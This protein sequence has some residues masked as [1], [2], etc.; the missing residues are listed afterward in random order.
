MHHYKNPVKMKESF[1][2][3][4]GLPKVSRAQFIR[5]IDALKNIS[6]VITKI[7]NSLYKTTINLI[8]T[9]YQHL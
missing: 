7:I 8:E 4:H 2:E 5:T 1:R 6:S 9:I 3:S